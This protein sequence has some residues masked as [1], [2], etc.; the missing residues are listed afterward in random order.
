MRYEDWEAGVPSQ[1]KSEAMWNFFGYRKALFLYDL[2]WK[3]CETLLKHPLGKT[4]A[5]SSSEVLALFL[6]TSRKATVEAIAKTDST[7]CVSLSDL[8]AKVKAGTIAPK[9][10]SRQK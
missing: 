5:R 10:Y 9:N 4:V 3:D 1:I 8:L 7:S 2:C 6:P